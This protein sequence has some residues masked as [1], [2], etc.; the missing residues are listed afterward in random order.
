MIN[1]DKLECPIS[2][3]SIIVAIENIGPLLKASTSQEMVSNQNDANVVLYFTQ[4]VIFSLGFGNEQVEFR[5]FH[6]PLTLMKTKSDKGLLLPIKFSDKTSPDS[7]IN[8]FGRDVV[9]IFH[10]IEKDF[11]QIH[12]HQNELL[13]KT[14]DEIEACCPNL[15]YSKL[16]DTSLLN[17]ANKL[18][19]RLNKFLGLR[20]WAEEQ[21]SSLLHLGTLNSLKGL[22]RDVGALLV[23]SPAG[24]SIED[25]KD[26]IKL[27]KNDDLELILQN[28]SDMGFITRKKE[29]NNNLLYLIS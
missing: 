8:Q 1:I 11:Q 24:L 26:R 21:G 28:L 17:L 14:L 6:G 10:F 4:R 16:T 3:V 19:E 13:E 18:K 15:D 7:R 22:H 9:F 27:S 25:I 20:I 5:K 2:D 29:K 12:N 23:G